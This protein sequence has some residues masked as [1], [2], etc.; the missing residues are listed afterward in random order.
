VYTRVEQVLPYCRFKNSTGY[1]GMLEDNS[2]NRMGFTIMKTGSASCDYHG[3]W[4]NADRPS[5]SG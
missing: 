2:D 1:M 5:E 3:S 4:Q